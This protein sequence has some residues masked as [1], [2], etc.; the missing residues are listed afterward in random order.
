MHPEE[1][2]SLAHG[3]L[4]ARYARTLESLAAAREVY[5]LLRS[6]LP[7]DVRA[8]RK[9]AKQVYDLE[10][11]QTVLARELAQMRIVQ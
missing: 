11:L 1:E 2:V 5:R 3:P 10:Q 8:L 4:G 7:V 9:A 6:Q